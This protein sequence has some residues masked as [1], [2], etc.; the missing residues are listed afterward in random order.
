MHFGSEVELKMILHWDHHAALERQ[1]MPSFTEDPTGLSKSVCYQIPLSHFMLRRGNETT[2]LKTKVPCSSHVFPLLSVQKEQF[3][4]ISLEEIW[5]FF[6]ASVAASCWK[7]IRSTW[8]GWSRCFLFQCCPDRAI[9]MAH[10]TSREGCVC[11]R[12][13]GITEGALVEESWIQ[14]ASGH[15]VIFWAAVA[16][17]R[18]MRNTLGSFLLFSWD[19]AVLADVIQTQTPPQT[20]RHSHRHTHMH[21]WISLVAGPALWCPPALRP[22]DCPLADSGLWSLP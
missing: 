13:H 5:E 4:K 18:N 2:A 22:W 6:C 11:T 12:K 1:S 19:P 17:D 15:S 3:I 9:L 16:T 8:Q 21:K 7:N 14:E 20:H 10:S